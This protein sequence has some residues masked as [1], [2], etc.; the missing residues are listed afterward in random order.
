MTNAHDHNRHATTTMGG[1][2]ISVEESFGEPLVC[3]DFNNGSDEMHLK[4]PPQS[5]ERFAEAILHAAQTAMAGS[6]EARWGS[7]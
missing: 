6:Y 7:I 4:L 3:I 2:K 1:M 5:A